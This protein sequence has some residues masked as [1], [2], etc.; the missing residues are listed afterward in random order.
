MSPLQPPN[1]QLAREDNYI[2]LTKAEGGKPTVKGDLIVEAEGVARSPQG[3]VATLLETESST[4]HPLNC[5]ANLCA[6]IE[7]SS[8]KDYLLAKCLRSRVGLERFGLSLSGDFV[9]LYL[10]S[11][12]FVSLVEVKSSN[13]LVG[14][15]SYLRLVQVVD[16]VDWHDVLVFPKYIEP[17]GRVFHKFLSTFKG[18]SKKSTKFHIARYKA[19]GEILLTLSS[20]FVHEIDKQRL[21][22][23]HDIIDHLKNVGLELSWLEAHLGCFEQVLEHT[24]FVKEYQ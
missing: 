3:I 17:L 11:S 9:K 1:P 12:S 4:L 13:R 20:H 16:R 14:E 18:F 7:V 10:R 8:R 6:F 24:S 5:Q 19:L 21:R 15:V 22:V 2:D 23:F